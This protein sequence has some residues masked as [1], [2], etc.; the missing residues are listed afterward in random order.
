MLFMHS[1]VFLE[2]HSYVSGKVGR[3]SQKY[4][5]F[6]G[7]IN[8]MGQFRVEPVANYPAGVELNILRLESIIYVVVHLF[9]SSSP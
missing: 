5:W 1:L 8:K 7:L 3:F 9:L 2:F 6:S 4:L